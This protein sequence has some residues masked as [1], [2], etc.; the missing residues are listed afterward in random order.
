MR[1]TSIWSENS[2]AGAAAMP[3]SSSSNS[4]Q[5]VVPPPVDP[6]YNTD[7]R[8]R[9]IFFP[10]YF[11]PQCWASDP[12]FDRVKAISLCDDI[13]RFSVSACLNSAELNT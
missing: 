10:P 2:A 7:L 3:S 1:S 9:S 5:L 6:A 4:R 8:R 13:L 12:E 11:S